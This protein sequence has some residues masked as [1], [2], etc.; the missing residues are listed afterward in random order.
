VPSLLEWLSRA[1]IQPDQHHGRA[2]VS[3]ISHDSRRV[4]PG[5]V[6][7][8]VPSQS[9]DTHDFLPAAQAGGA[10][11]ALVHSP[12]GVQLAVELGLEAVLVSLDEQK[13]NSK[14]ELFLSVQGRFADA[15]WKLALAVYGESITELIAVT[16]TNGKTSIAWLIQHLLL[17]LGES[18]AYLGTLGLKTP[19]EVRELANTTPAT[20]ETYA[21][22]HSLNTRYLAMEVSSHALS[23][24]RVEGLT[25]PVAVYSNLS[26]DHLDYHGTMEAYEAAKAR[27]FSDFGV[28]TAILN[29]NDPA[30]RAIA[31][32]FEGEVRW[33]GND[34]SEIELNLDRTSFVMAGHRVSSRLIGTYNVE[35]LAAAIQAVVALGYPLEKVVT[36]AATVPPVPGRLEPVPNDHGIGVWIDYAHTPDGL[37]KVL[38]SVRPIAPEAKIW[39]VFGCGG[40]RDKEKRPIMGQIAEELS[41]HVVVTSDNPRTEDTDKI[42]SDILKGMQSNP[43]TIPDRREAVAF[44]VKNAAPGDLVV[45]AGKGH[46]N[47]QIIGTTKFPMDDRELVRDGLAAR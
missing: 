46:E 28:R 10:K 17:G 22:V 44:A 20:L 33:F 37:R 19:T 45:V 5:S 35:N 11:A 26:Q 27:L 29:A 12:G 40:D 32:D 21:L 43:S 23:Q 31:E 2:E 42:I 38:E 14:E 18:A 25:F 34:A 16:G 3:A 7:V 41:D 1:G 36:I 8:C 4:Q 30:T 47:Y 6:F 15:T 39:T 9:R 13:G 24:R